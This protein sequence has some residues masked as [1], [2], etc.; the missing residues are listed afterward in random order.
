M[1][2]IIFILLIL[3]VNTFAVDFY[4]GKELFRK[5]VPDNFE[6]NN[7][8]LV[9]G[10]VREDK[11]E[12]LIFNMTNSRYEKS[13]GISLNRYAEINNKFSAFCGIGV[14]SG[15]KRKTITTETEYIHFRN[16]NEIMLNDDVMLTII[17]GIEYKI[18]ENVMIDT[19]MM[20]SCV[21]TMLK[22]KL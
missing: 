2:K 9:F 3:S 12:L 15:Y 21:T 11:N 19:L 13:F 10:S 16:K 18:N 4:L 20:G 1:K 8:S 6:N 22:V 7:P 14:A 5:H 17:V